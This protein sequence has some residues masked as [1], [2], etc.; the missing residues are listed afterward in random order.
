MAILA[1]SL[2]CA[3]APTAQA[4]TP[5]GAGPSEAAFDVKRFQVAHHFLDFVVDRDTLFFS[6]GDDVSALP[7]LYSYALSTGEE[8]LVARASSSDATISTIAHADGWALFVETFPAGRVLYRVRATN[9][10]RDVV[11]DE[12]AAPDETEATAWRSMTPIPMV[13]TAAG[14]AAWTTTAPAAGPTH[15]LSVASLTTGARITIRSAQWL[16]FPSLSG[17]TLVYT[18]G[19]SERHLWALRPFIETE[20]HQLLKATDVS[21]GSIRGDLV[22]YKKGG[23]DALDPGGIGLLNMRTNE[24]LQVAPA[25]EQGWQPTIGRRYVV[26]QGSPSEIRAYDL[27]TRQVVVIARADRDT[28]GRP[29]VLGRVAAFGSTI[30]W[31]SSPPGDLT[32][33][34]NLKPSFNVLRAP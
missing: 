18:E 4:P 17:G 21:E 13:T 25:T 31:L 26:W 29:G 12:L 9:G 11:L 10:P 7:G 33:V 14:L 5:S 8:S 15:M 34:A 30:V 22:A 3:V 1:T 6:G 27:R 23:R 32:D 16:S 20:P 19:R 28:K 2:A 24:E